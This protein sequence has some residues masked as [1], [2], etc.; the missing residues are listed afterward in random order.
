MNRPW[1]DGAIEVLFGVARVFVPP[2]GA[3]YECTMNEADYAVLKSRRSCAMLS[4]TDMLAGKVP[5]TP[6]TASVIGG[7]QT[8]EAV[9]L[10]HPQ[11]QLPTLAS[12]GFHFNGLT[13]DSYVV[14]YPRRED[15]LGH[16]TFAAVEERPW[17]AERLTLAEA[18]GAGRARLGPE[19]VLEFEQEVVIGL[20]CKQCDTTAGAVPRAGRG[21]GRR[22]ALSRLRGDSRAGDDARDLGRGALPG[23]DAG[24]AGAAA[25]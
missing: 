8:Q 16:F 3:C 14:Q 13:H 11:S 1:V 7:I 19:A 10:L 12:K 17:Q 22:G 4:R 21:D 23:D 15:C 18:L 5:T 25:L 24:C 9:K 6:T 2:D 20:T